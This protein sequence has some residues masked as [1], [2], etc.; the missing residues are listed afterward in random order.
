MNS[1]M[2]QGIFD[3]LNPETA[4]RW[5]YPDTKIWSADR[6]TNDFVTAMDDWHAHGLLSFTVNMQGGSPMGYGNKNWYNS[7][8]QED[9]E[10]RA[11]YMARLKKILDKADELGMAPILGL[12]YF[13]QDQNLKDDPAVIN[14]TENVIDWLFDQGYRH[15][16]IE[17]ANECDNK[18][19]DRDII[20]ADRIHELINLI[21]SKQKDGHRFPVSTSYN[22]KPNSKREC[23]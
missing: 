8:Y 20:K 9:G 1:R 10:L 13:G 3:D 5:K 18:A 6:N 12:F 16:L 15:V 7:A 4:V 23:S 11:D 17:V 21:K 14:A 19:Y 22:G 2:V